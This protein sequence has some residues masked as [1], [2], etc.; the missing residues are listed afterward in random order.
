MDKNMGWELY[1]SLLGVL[2]EGSLS[3]AARALGIAQPTVGRHITALEETLG[4]VLFT[5][6][7]AGLLPTEAALALQVHAE[8]ME[9]SAAALERAAAS[10][11]K[12][13]SGVVRITASEVVGVEVLPPII[14]NLCATYPGLKIEL[15]LSDRTQ[16]LLQ[17]EADIAVRM[18]RPAQ[19]QLIARHV[20]QVEV[21][22]HASATYLQ[23]RGT[24]TSVAQ[25][26]EHTLIGFDQPTPYIREVAKSMRG[27]DRESFALRTDSSVAQL[28]L[29]R[30]GA[31][32][33]FCQV[34]LAR[35]AASATAGA[36]NPQLVRV[37]PDLYS[38]QLDTWITM[39]EGLRNN[40][41]C[42]ATFDALVVGM[43][44]YLR[45]VG[46]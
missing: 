9:S 44:S 17:R 26:T 7:Q 37:I 13:V 43:E 24:P 3:G 21:G 14:A 15:S 4:L 33:G 18:V 31:G 35:G 40:P 1:R 12:G 34:P 39:H 5:R 46:I 41:S 23:R 19:D 29:M 22:L 20:G 38:F 10:Q 42:K 6:T 36:A 16:D 8:E 25:L 27:L 45:G 28:A 30:S 2:R 11:G 32:I